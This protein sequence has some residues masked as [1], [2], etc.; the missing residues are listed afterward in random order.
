[1]HNQFRVKFGNL[2]N[3]AKFTIPGDKS[4]CVYRKNGA[5]IEEASLSMKSLGEFKRTILSLNPLTEVMLWPA[6]EVESSH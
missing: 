5:I 6:Q 3:M 2:A 1:V 4:N